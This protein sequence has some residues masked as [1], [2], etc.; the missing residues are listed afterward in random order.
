MASD[1]LPSLQVLREGSGTRITA[2]RLNFLFPDSEAGEISDAYHRLIVETE[3]R[4]TPRWKAFAGVS[5]GEA[6]FLEIVQE[7]TLHWMY[8]YALHQLPLE[9]QE[10]DWDHPQTR[11]ILQGGVRRHLPGDAEAQARLSAHLMGLSI[12]EYLKWH[13]V[14]DAFLSMW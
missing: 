3:R 2:G 14:D 5:I 7:I 9:I 1:P 8:F 4:F 10:A 13:E 11:R 12:A 6:P